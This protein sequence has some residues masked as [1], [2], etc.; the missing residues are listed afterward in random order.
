MIDRPDI[1]KYTSKRER[2]KNITRKN[3][4]SKFSNMLAY[5][6]L[7]LNELNNISSVDTI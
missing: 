6:A 2:N 1:D 7:N 4:N 5:D 3:I